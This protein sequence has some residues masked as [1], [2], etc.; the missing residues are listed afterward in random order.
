MNIKQRITDLSAES[1]LLSGPAKSLETRAKITG[2]TEDIEKAAAARI[3]LE[4][5]AIKIQ[6]LRRL[7]GVGFKTLDAIMGLFPEPKEPKKTKKGRK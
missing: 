3:P 2:A 7:A 5:C 6:M 1:R 4:H